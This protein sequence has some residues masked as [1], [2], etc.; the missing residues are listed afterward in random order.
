MAKVSFSKLKCKVNEEV[1]VVEF[2]GEAIEVK[3]YLPI[4]DKLGLIGRAVE[5]A[6]DADYNYSNP[7]KA[8]VF[9]E[10]EILYAYTN[11]TFTDKQKEDVPKLYD[12]VLSSGLLKAVFDAI[13]EEELDKIYVGIWKTIDSIYSYRQ[14]VLGILDT[15]STDYENLDFNVQDIM[16]KIKDPESLDLVK[17]LLT[18]LN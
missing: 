7:V 10:L 6:H 18:N 5:F 8:N 9:R 15:L 4:Q 2:A 3:Q 11:I 12:M 1:K 14:S 17:G 13:P 16:N